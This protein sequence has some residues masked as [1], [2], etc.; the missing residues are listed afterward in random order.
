VDKAMAMTDEDQ[1]AEAAFND[2]RQAKY[3]AEKTMR[4]RDAENAAAAWVRFINLYLPADQK[5]PTT[6]IIPMHRRKGV[7]Q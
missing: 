2:Y 7:V 3:L 4:F 6:K 5:M 1:A